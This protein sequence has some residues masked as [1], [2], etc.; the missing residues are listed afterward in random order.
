MT[1]ENVNLILT[2]ILALFII[3]V[4]SMTSPTSCLHNHLRQ[5]LFDKIRQF[6]I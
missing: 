6:Y 3:N 4:L 2:D 1:E 5:K